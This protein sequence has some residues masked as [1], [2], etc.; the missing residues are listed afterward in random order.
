MNCYSFFFKEIVDLKRLRIALEK[1][2]THVPLKTMF[3]SVSCKIL[4]NIWLSYCSKVS[5]VINEPC[6]NVR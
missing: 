3:G 2:H 4:I 6:L 5:D 1:R